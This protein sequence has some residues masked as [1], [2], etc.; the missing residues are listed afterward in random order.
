MRYL[1]LLLI[2]VFLFSGCKYSLSE[3]DSPS[4]S[5]EE[6]ESKIESWGVDGERSN[7]LLYQLVVQ[8]EKRVEK[9]ELDSK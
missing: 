6:A 4:S 5:Y 9:L 2:C 1:F 3:F 7:F 8:L